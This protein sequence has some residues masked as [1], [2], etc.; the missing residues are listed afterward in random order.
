MVLTILLYFLVQ[1]HLVG[2]LYRLS[3]LGIMNTLPLTPQEIAALVLVW[4]L[5]LA[6]NIVYWTGCLREGKVSEQTVIDAVTETLMLEDWF[7]D[8]QTKLLNEC[9]LK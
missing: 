8:N 9:S 2:N 4:R 6:S 1:K 7:E 5:Q 3:A